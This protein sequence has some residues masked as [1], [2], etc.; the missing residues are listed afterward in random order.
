MLPCY[1]GF[2]ASGRLIWEV[3]GRGEV[4]L[5]IIV[6]MRHLSTYIATDFIIYF[7]I[8]WMPWMKVRIP[9]NQQTERKNV[10]S[11]LFLFLRWADAWQAPSDWL[12]HSLWHKGFQLK[13][14]SKTILRAINF[15]SANKSIMGRCMAGLAHSLWHKGLTADIFDWMCALVARRN[16]NWS[17]RAKQS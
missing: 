9:I 5:G 13:W 10:E 17:D 6:P 7:S 3:L 4:D 11:K 1:R 12:A 2:W 14:R 15:F 8:Q 16:S